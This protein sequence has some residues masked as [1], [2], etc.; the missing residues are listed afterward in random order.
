MALDA[1]GADF[2]VWTG[3]GRQYGGEIEVEVAQRSADGAWS[4]PVILGHGTNSRLAM[5]AGG[6]AVVVW[7]LSRRIEAATTRAGGA[8]TATARLGGGVYPQVAINSNGNSTAVWESDYSAPAVRS[9]TGRVGGSWGPPETVAAPLAGHERD[10]R[11][12]VAVDTIGDAV[13]VWTVGATT[14]PWTTPPWFEQ[15][16]SRWETNGA[17]KWTSPAHGWHT[18][19]ADRTRRSRPRGRRLEPRT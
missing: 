9:A 3:A 5:N 10:A 7:Q 2:A 11:P 12:V 4:K 15:R 18:R 1:R 19:P 14:P 17:P 16:P 13:A 8:W 6:D